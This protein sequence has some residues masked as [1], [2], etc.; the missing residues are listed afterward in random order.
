MNTV[1]SAP[2]AAHLAIRNPE[3]R[4]PAA[5]AA[6]PAA[7]PRAPPGTAPAWP[8][9]GGAPAGAGSAGAALAG[10][11]RR[12]IVACGPRAAWVRPSRSPSRP[13]APSSAATG[14]GLR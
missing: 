10:A 1:P 14:P 4:V 12:V 8:A 9:R 13:F 11:R 6:A 3:P 2:T 5:P 7:A